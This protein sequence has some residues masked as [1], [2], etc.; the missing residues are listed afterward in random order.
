M[1]RSLLDTDIFSE[2]VKGK[3]ANVVRAVGEYL[4]AHDR[5][6]ISAM[7]VMEVSYGL[8]R[9][10]RTAQLAAFE[11]MLPTIEVLPLDDGRP[12]RRAPEGRSRRTRNT[13]RRIR[14]HDRRG[15]HHRG[16]PARDRQRCPLRVRSHRRS[17]ADD[18]E[19]A[20]VTRRQAKSIDP[21]WDEAME[22]LLDGR[23]HKAVAAAIGCH[24]NTI[25]N[26]MRSSAFRVEL[27]R[28]SDERLAA[29]KQRL[30]I[31]TTRL[32][33]RLGRLA[34]DAMTAAERDPTDRRAQHAARDWL[35][36]YRDLCRVEAQ[37]LGTGVH[38]T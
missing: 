28:R 1:T 12:T 17:C 20:S 14:R 2:V 5:L 16:H 21:R 6:T 33:D 30:A 37:I 7:T 24:R 9:A 26:W 18:R 38:P 32:V 4:A 13:D 36:N 15:R 10:G 25:A 19:L 29:A 31:V 22:L 8:R 23:S 27:A 34:H 35:R 11:A 3:N